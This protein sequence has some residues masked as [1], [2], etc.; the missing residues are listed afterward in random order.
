MHQI[1][2]FGLSVFLLIVHLLPFI[3]P[4]SQEFTVVQIFY[5]KNQNFQF[6]DRE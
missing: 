2:D 4:D 6:T 5:D 1:K 3:S